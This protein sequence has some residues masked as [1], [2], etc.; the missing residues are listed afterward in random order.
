M[1]GWSGSDGLGIKLDA[2][3][4]QFFPIDNIPP[5]SLAMT[6]ALSS[7]VVYAIEL[8]EF[9]KEIP[10]A[11]RSP[12][13]VPLADAPS[14]AILLVML[15][16]EGVCENDVVRKRCFLASTSSSSNFFLPTKIKKTHSG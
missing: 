16:K 5:S 2:F 6:S 4:L 15:M 14:A 3:H 13:V 8:L 12:G 1:T 9:P 10:I 7:I 11:C